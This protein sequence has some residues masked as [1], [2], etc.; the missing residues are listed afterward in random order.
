MSALTSTFQRMP[1]IITRKY[2][3]KTTTEPINTTLKS[4]TTATTS[5]KSQPSPVDLGS[6]ENVLIHPPPAIPK[7]LENVEIVRFGPG[8]F[9]SKLVSKK[10]VAKG[11]EVARIENMTRNVKKRW[12]SVQV[13]EEEHIE[14]DP[15]SG[16][17]FMN[18]SC[19]PS[20]FVDTTNFRIIAL[21]DINPG[22]EVTFFYPSTEWRM[23]QPFTCWCGSPNCVSVV[24]G[25]SEMSSEVL[26]GFRVNQHIQRLV[27]LRDHK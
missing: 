11:Q 24:K 12:S 9:S 26:K 21:R 6:A 25:A 17:V 15:A 2:T 3:S 14:L 23:D 8:E 27:T 5:T 10:F 1:M 20:V 7:N 19:S 13:A 22:D 4:T 16:L 18:H